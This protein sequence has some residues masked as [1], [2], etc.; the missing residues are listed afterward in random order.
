MTFLSPI[1]ENTHKVL[2]YLDGY[3]KAISSIEPFFVLEG[4]KLVEI[5]QNIPKEL[6]RFKRYAAELKSIEELLTVR[7]EEYEGQR[8]KLYNQTNN[9]QL[10]TKDIQQYI[11]GEKEYVDYCEL[12]LEITFLRN[13]MNAIIESLDVM[14][15]QM[16]HITKLQVS[17]LEQV[18]L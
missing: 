5:C 13:N 1:A 3:Q 8:W 7:R 18:V 11:K 6:V 2:E 12:I 10:T 15:W 14:N 17:M 16:G 9:K 4:R